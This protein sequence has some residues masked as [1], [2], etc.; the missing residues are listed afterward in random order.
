MSPTN[1]YIPCHNVNACHVVGVVTHLML[2]RA[3]AAVE[4]SGLSVTDIDGAIAQ[5]E[6]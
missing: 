5:K 1:D 3:W 4:I 6:I 2:S